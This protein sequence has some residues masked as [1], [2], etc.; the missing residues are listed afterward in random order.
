RW[1]GENTVLYLEKAEMISEYSGG[2]PASEDRFALWL[3]FR[4][5][6]A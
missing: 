2:V 5:I 6:D 4:A 1:D 3:H